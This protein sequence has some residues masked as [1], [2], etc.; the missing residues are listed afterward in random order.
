[1]AIFSI[2]QWT[3]QYNMMIMMIPAQHAGMHDI[4]VEESYNHCLLTLQWSE[5]KYMK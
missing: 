3:M 1:M 2:L 5:Y 4:Q